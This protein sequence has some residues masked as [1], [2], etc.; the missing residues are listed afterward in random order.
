MI[1]KFLYFN[2]WSLTLSM[3]TCL[4]KRV[5][6]YLET[7]G[8][9]RLIVKLLENYVIL[10]LLMPIMVFLVDE[11]E[12]TL[13][14]IVKVIAI[15]AIVLYLVGVCYQAIGVVKKFHKERRVSKTCIPCEDSLAINILY[16]KM[17]AEHMEAYK[18]EICQNEVIWI[19]YARGVFRKKIVLPYGMFYDYTDKELK[20]I[21]IHELSHHKHRDLMFRYFCHFIACIYWFNPSIYQLIEDLMSFEETIADLFTCES[22]E[23]DLRKDEYMRFLIRLQNK[24]PRVRL[25]KACQNAQDLQ[26][27]A[28]RMVKG[29]KKKTQSIK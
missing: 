15:G 8:N 28:K 10:H 5:I 19:P 29:N 13:N 9:Y 2:A 4:G 11:K 12:I 24:N 3:V 27:R 21:I 14:N 17:K 6:N 20:L 25:E 23:V 1:Q 22:L 7:T 18:I 26:K 16:S